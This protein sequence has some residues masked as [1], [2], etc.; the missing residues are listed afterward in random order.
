[1]DCVVP[2]FGGIYAGRRVLV[3]G[4]TG[5]KGS[6]LTYWLL[7]LGATVTGYAQ[8]PPT[9]PSLFD[10]LCLAE[11][12]NHHIGDVQDL[13]HLSEVMIAAQP[14]IV[15]HLAAQPLVR[16]S[17][18]EPVET[19]ATNVMGTVNL[20]EAVRATPSLRAVVNVTSDKCYENREW[21]FAYRENDPMGGFDPYS[22]SKACSELVTSAYRQSFLRGE[23][24][25]A[26]ATAR[27]GNVI[28][29]GDW[30][31]D[32]IVPD[33]IRALS[34]DE[35][36]VVR[37]PD[38]VRPW[39]HVLEPTSGYL[40]LASRLFRD[41]HA[42]A[43]A[44]NFGPASGST[45]TVREVVNF[46]IVEWGKGSWIGSEPDVHHAH[47]ARFLKLDCSKAVDL[48]GWRPVWETQRGLHAAAQWYRE[49]YCGDATAEQLTAEC[50]AAYTRA[51]ISTPG[52]SW[53]TG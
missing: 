52:M 33:C 24:A 9:S 4:H 31:L 18:K 17:Y 28:G 26:V 49:F 41:A 22:A 47:E 23:S 46:I 10:E 19:F 48:L 1:M 12:I 39:Q 38:A 5:F 13:A 6:W 42:L 51:A 27:A 50:L 37:S 35:P 8:E 32:R 21:E 30:A 14:E 36:V 7:A 3:T 16:L 20:L 2:L 45:L 25:A 15:F 34:A 53:V 40:L 11:R 29:G 44:W 43:G